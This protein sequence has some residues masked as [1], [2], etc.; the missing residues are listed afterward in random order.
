[1]ESAESAPSAKSMF[2]LLIA[3][4]GLP[5]PWDITPPDPFPRR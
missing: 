1:M 5:E 3:S 4:T 2:M